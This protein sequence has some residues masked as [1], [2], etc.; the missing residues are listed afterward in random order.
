MGRGY[1]KLAMLLVAVAL[2]S[3]V[4]GYVT[5]TRFIG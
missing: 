4:L 3:L 2:V 5:M 1:L